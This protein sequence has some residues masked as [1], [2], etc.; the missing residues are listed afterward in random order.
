MIGNGTYITGSKYFLIYFY[1]RN[2]FSTCIDCVNGNC[3]DDTKYLLKFGYSFDS[4]LITVSCGYEPYD[5]AFHFLDYES[6]ARELGNLWHIKHFK[7]DDLNIT[8]TPLIY[9]IIF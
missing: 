4:I 7:A 9:R 1:I 6:L 3:R 2:E 8:A 5:V